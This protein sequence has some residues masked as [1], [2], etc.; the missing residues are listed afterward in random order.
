MGATT[1]ETRAT[2]GLPQSIFVVPAVADATLAGRHFFDHPWPSD[3]RRDANG[4]IVVTGYYNPFG[5]PIL[6]PR[7]SRR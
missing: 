4:N 5:E 6:D 7:T 1:R 2:R 3:Y